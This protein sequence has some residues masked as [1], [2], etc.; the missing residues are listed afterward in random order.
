MRIG[1][2][3]LK[4]PE[5]ASR[6]PLAS[7]DHAHQLGMDGI[8][9]RTAQQMSPTLDAAEFRAIRDR[10]DELGLYVETGLGK[11]NP[12]ANPETPE[13]RAA[14]DGDIVLGA[15]RIMEACAAIDCRELWCSTGSYKS[16]YRGRWAYDR[17]RSDV[18]WVEQLEA[19][20]RFVRKLA[21]IARDLGLHLNFETHEE[22]TS[23]EVVRLVEA[24][25]P[26]VVGIVYDVGNPL[27]RLEHPAWTARRVAP[28][29]RQ[30]HVKDV[31]LVRVPGGLTFQSRPCG[32]GLVDFHT[33]LPIIA[34]V[35]PDL[36]LSIENDT[37]RSER[38]KPPSRMI[39]EV[40]APDFV[41]AQ[42]DLSREELDDY[43]GLVEA[44]GK[45]MA[46]GEVVDHE[47]YAQQPFEYVESVAF[48]Q[49]SAGYLRQVALAERLPLAQAP[50]TPAVV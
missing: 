23:F 48:I 50:L 25:G 20:E 38:T 37:P 22:I 41:A 34:A 18:S 31:S 30:T 4:I 11:M 44:F 6:G 47:Q 26:D 13:F 5:S 8:F 16:V 3:G 40:D 35:N 10:A 7:V 39:I 36:N 46:A 28:Y 14:G 2:D 24:V 19:T 45:R 33:V 21:P 27:Q 29:V 32:T 12:Y 15:R 1:V 49:K 43:L 17:F 42:P 9:F